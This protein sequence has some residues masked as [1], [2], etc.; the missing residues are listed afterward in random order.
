V[1]L[2]LLGVEGGGAQGVPLRLVAAVC[3]FV[4]RSSLIGWVANI[5]SMAL[6]RLRPFFWSMRISPT[7]P[8]GL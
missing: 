7:M 2:G 1:R 8:S 6:A 5:I 4:S 3:T